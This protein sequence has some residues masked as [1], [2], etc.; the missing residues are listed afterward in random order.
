MPRREGARA[1]HQTTLLTSAVLLCLLQ[2]AFSASLRKRN[3]TGGVSPT[4]DEYMMGSVYVSGSVITK[5]GGV[6]LISSDSSS[7]LDGVE[8][9]EEVGV[10]GEELASRA[11]ALHQESQDI[12]KAQDLLASAFPSLSFKDETSSRRLSV[13]NATLSMMRRVEEDRQNSSRA[14]ASMKRAISLDEYAKEREGRGYLHTLIRSREREECRVAGRT[15]ITAG[16]LLSRN[17]HSSLA[18]TMPASLLF[19]VSERGARS[20][21]IHTLRGNTTDAGVDGDMK[22]YFASS[23]HLPLSSLLDHASNLTGSSGE[24]GEARRDPHIA[25]QA[26]VA[27]MGM[28]RRE[29]VDAS[30]SWSY[31]VCARH[32]SSLE[33]GGGGASGG[34]S[35]QNS[36]VSSVEKCEDV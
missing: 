25:K 16:L 10:R 21:F 26:W 18:D 1:F 14:Y 28:G 8:R 3:E 9:L 29:G 4:L 27:S 13:S 36:S 5:G 22:F 35:V 31:Y 17:L 24:K 32:L 7:T 2:L 11:Q 23:S 15:A 34:E 19:A 12:G 6:H 33:E 30:H 20:H